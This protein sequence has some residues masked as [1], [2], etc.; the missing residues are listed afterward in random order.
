MDKAITFGKNNSLVGILTIPDQSTS[1]KEIG[2]I[3]LNAGLLHR[4]GPFRMNVELANYLAKEGY[5]TLRFDSS[6]I[7]DSGNANNETDY[8]QSVTQDIKRAVDLMESRT[9]LKQFVI[10]GLCTGADNGHRA[11]THDKRIVGG[12]FLDGYSYPSLKFMIKHY[13]PIFMSPS[14]V[15]KIL[16]RAKRFIL[17]RILRTSAS[18]AKVEAENIFTWQLPNKK[19][20]EKELKMLLGRGAKLFYVFSCTALNRYNYENQYFDSMPFLKQFR[21]QFRVILNMNT[22]HTYRLYHD[23]LWLYNEVSDWLDSV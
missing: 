13:L 11:M 16:S 17:H 2:V 7:G 8:L 9:S 20:T 1:L 12:I 21:H 15:S 14:V 19:K 22:D 23:R 6:S 18:A 5:S 3:C 4:V 10:F